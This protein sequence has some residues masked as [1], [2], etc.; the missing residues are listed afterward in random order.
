MPPIMIYHT[1][2]RTTDGMQI[3]PNWVNHL[4]EVVGFGVSD[5]A[6][7][8]LQVSVQKSQMDKT[9][10]IET[11]LFYKVL[12]P[13]FASKFKWDGDCLIKGQIFVKTDSVP[14][15]ICKSECAIKF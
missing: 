12:Y 8:D 14:G 13:N 9:L 11:A 6:R 3:K 15:R 5:R 4:P 7:N 2:S 10:F 1:K